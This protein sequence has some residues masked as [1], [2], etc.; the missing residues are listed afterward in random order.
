VIKLEALRQRESFLRREVFVEGAQRVRIQVVLNHP[1]LKGLRKEPCQF[2]EK[3][4]VFLF[5][6]LRMHLREPFPGERFERCEQRTR[7]VLFIGLMF[8]ARLTALQRQWRDH[9]AD[10]KTRALIETDE[11]VERVIRLP[12][13]P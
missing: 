6:A 12:I 5:G 13:Q 2:F 3:E 7:T 10:Q 11:W 8:F 9:I 1:N 4:R